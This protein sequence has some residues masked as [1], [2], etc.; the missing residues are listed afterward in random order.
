MAMKKKSGF[1]LIELLVVISII[2]L[3]LSILMPAL[4]KAK[5]LAKNVLC[6]SNLRQWGL[7]YNMYV[8][9]YDGNMSDGFSKTSESD[10]EPGGKWID[11]MRIYY[12]DVENPEFRFCPMAD[13][14]QKNQNEE[15]KNF[16]IWD[17]EAYNNYNS[18]FVYNMRGSYTFNAWLY[19]PV[20]D[21]GSEIGLYGRPKW[22]FW[23]NVNR[24]KQ[25]DEVPV[26]ADGWFWD[27]APLESDSPNTANPGPGKATGEIGRFLIN[28]HQNGITS[29]AFVD[30]SVQKMY[31]KG[32]WEYPW[33]K[34]FDTKRDPL[35]GEDWPDW[36]Q[37]FPEPK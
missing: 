13:N 14:P 36:M 3:L 12:S 9:D 37:G 35:Q 20:D 30:G 5:L 2:A 19:N 34:R 11:S 22:N 23:R 18:P 28:R 27:S 15:N 32:L 6:K 4:S 24:I 31:L 25:A 10:F 29:G 21:G 1:T 33:S 17:T 8:I 16:T 26:F 7:V